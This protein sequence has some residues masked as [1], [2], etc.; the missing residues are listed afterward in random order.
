MRFENLFTVSTVA[1]S[2]SITPN[3]HNEDDIDPIQSLLTT[4]GSD[5]GSEYDPN[6]EE[7]NLSDSQDDVEVV[8]E[9]PAEKAAAEKAGDVAKKGKASKKKA[10]KSEK[11][12]KS[13]KKKPPMQNTCPTEAETAPK[14]TSPSSDSDSDDFDPPLPDKYPVH[15]ETLAANPEWE[16][17]VA[18]SGP[19]P[20]R[21]AGVK[22]H[23]WNSKLKYGTRP[24]LEVVD[25][26]R[27]V[28]KDVAIWTWVVK[29]RK[30]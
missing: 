24:P 16:A 10:E 20:R 18:Q 4:Y 15:P 25:G 2:S 5:S 13:R 28:L 6:A 29:N 12:S 27:D 22:L 7:R 3:P 9:V 21:Y 8:E 30:R 11:S 14:P 23:G 19:P 17:K 1:K 26:F